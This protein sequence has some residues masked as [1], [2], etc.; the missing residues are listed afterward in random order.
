MG[1]YVDR[2]G[3]E[4]SRFKILDMKIIKD[5]K[6]IKSRYSGFVGNTLFS[7]RYIC[8]AKEEGGLDLQYRV[9]EYVFR[10]YF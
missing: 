10:E 2:F 1:Y 6:K 9:L 8:K 7:D 3:Y 4:T 5:Y